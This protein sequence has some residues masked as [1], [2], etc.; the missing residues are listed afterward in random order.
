MK[1]IT[2]AAFGMTLLVM[3]CAEEEAPPIFQLIPVTTRDIVVSASAAG[4]VEPVRTVEVKSKASGEIMQVRV[5]T[6]DVVTAG[7]LLV[8][9]DPR[10]PRNYLRQTEADLDVAKA[11]L[12]NAESQLRRSDQL[13]ESQSITET[14]WEAARL[15]R[16]NARAQLIRAQRN[17]EDA[18]I[19]FEDTDVRAAIDGV[20]L[21]KNVEVGTVISSATSN[22]GGGTVL[23]RMA[24]LDTVQVRA[25]VDETD[26]GKIQPGMAVTIIVDAYPNQP[27][28]GTVLKIEPQ[29]TVQQNVTMFPVLARIDNSAGLLRPG[30][31]AEVEVH[32]GSREGVLAIPNAALRTTRDMGSAAGVLG[33]D[34]EVAQQQ[35]A[36][37]RSAARE[38]RG[39]RAT[40]GGRV[41][42]SAAAA[43]DPGGAHRET[44]EFQGR[45]IPLPAGVTAKQVTDIFAKMRDGGFSSVSAADRAIL[46][47]LRNASGGDGRR[48]RGGSRSGSNN[49]YL[50]GGDYVVFVM[51]DGIPTAVSVRT[52]LTDLDYSEVVSG[53]Q[54]TDTVIVLP[55]ASLLA[56][57]E[58]QQEFQDRIRSRS[59]P[60]V[61]RN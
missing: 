53:L 34:P 19:S 20:I 27:F 17:F 46:T 37:A 13:Y 41:A 11:T 31:N 4:Q 15:S 48:A 9:V 16:A 60:G 44:I 43:S 23:L 21:E 45:Q 33:I 59:M 14:D 6:G 52:G 5:E 47:K 2:S 56:S 25:L 32:V 38:S 29:A 7:Q 8:K 36:D 50:F 22:V 39:G 40:F 3:A 12:E 30:M 57:L 55:S 49:S 26:I 18:K 58:Q 10:V 1:K 24:D 51:R 28:R 61:R 54:P 35:L 42:D